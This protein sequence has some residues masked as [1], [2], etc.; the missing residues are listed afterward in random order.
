MNAFLNHVT[1]NSFKQDVIESEVPVLVDFWATWCAPCRSLAPILE[2]V[3][4][5]YR[6]KVKILK[7]NIE[8]NQNVPL[9][10]NVRGIPTVMLFKDGH[11][12]E[13][14]IGGHFSKSQLA[15]FLDSHL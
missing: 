1:D 12:I 7:M 5:E 9:Q 13:T 2:T 14:K 4:K 3:A 15:A 8:N 11:N 10:Y 6:G